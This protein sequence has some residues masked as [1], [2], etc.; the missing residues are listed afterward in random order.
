MPETK[1]IEVPIRAANRPQVPGRVIFDPLKPVDKPQEY[2]DEI[3]QK[4]AEARDLRLSYRPDGRSQYTSDLTGELAKYEI[5]PHVEATVQRDP[6]NDTV[7]VLFIG[8]G[9]SALLTAAR[10]R[11]RGVESIRIVERGGDVGGT[12]YWNRY[13]GVA[14]DVSA[15]DYLPLLSEMNYVPGSFYAKGPEIF[16]HCQAIA[17]RYDLYDLAV[18]QTT[19]TSTVWDAKAK[20]WRIGTDR[21]DTMSARFVI[22]ANG[23]LSK[24][25]LSKI[26]GMERFKGHS[27]HSSRFD[28]QYTKQDLAALKDKVVGIIGTGA[29]AVQII[30]RVGRAAKELFVFQRTPSAIDIRDDTP[31]DPQWAASLTPGWQKE[32][33][34]K[35]MRGPVLTEEQK[36]D[37]AALPRVEKIRRQENQN[38]EHMMRIHR[39]VEEIVR[40]KATAEALKPW[41]MHRCKRPCY[42][43]EYLPAFNR[44]N[45]HL[46]DTAGKGITEVSERGVVFEGR[47]YPVDVLIYAT[48]FEVQVTGIYN[49]IRGENGLELNEKYAEGMRTVFGIHSQGYPNLFIMGGYQASFQFNLTF[50]L[51]TQGDH[52][53]ECINHVRKHGHRTIDAA[54]ETEQW[55]VDE[56]I[57][58]RGKTN[59]NKECT[60]GYYNFEGENNRRQDGNYN[61]SFFQYF[62]HMTEVRKEMER[63]FHFA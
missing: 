46:V 42:D 39:R 4:F 31:T 32:R 57:R 8:G 49:E 58:H 43:D 53:A 62:T 34:E 60:P 50:M 5:D 27:F 18:F 2:Y 37:L 59:R 56:V 16:A 28:Y 55:W 17:R 12:W 40:D 9:F 11:E 25:K 30:P 22:C 6:I 21:G 20:L 26:G 36:R 63:H 47:E 48:G 29:S 7:E 44:P 45:V 3:K 54:P 13:P 38:I 19:V 33:R 24:P 15:Y 10:L 51:Q 23:T 61:G 1:E 35:H 41:Y 52:I 14:C